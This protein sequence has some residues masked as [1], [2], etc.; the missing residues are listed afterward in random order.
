VRSCY[1]TQGAQPDALDDEHLG[2]D[3]EG[4][5]WGKGE[6]PKREETYV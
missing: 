5:D 1:I 4:W 3:L 2:D 6:R